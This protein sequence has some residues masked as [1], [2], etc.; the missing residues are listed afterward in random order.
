VCRKVTAYII[1]EINEEKKHSSFT[2]SDT[3]KTDAFTKNLHCEQTSRSKNGYSRSSTKKT[4]NCDIPYDVRVFSWFEQRFNDVLL[5]DTL[6]RYEDIQEWDRE[7]L[8]HSIL[9]STA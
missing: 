7:R 5:P 3:I 8:T 9:L 1:D 2:I 4:K 6:V